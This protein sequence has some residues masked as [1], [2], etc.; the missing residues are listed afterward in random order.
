MGL[1]IV[2]GACWAL[3]FLPTLG[4]WEPLPEPAGA[5]QSQE[6]SEQQEDKE[7]GGAREGQETGDFPPTPPEPAPEEGALVV[8]PAGETPADDA[9]GV[10]HPRV[11]WPLGSEALASHLRGIAEAVPTIAELESLG[12]SAGGRE[13]FVLRLGLR[14]GRERDRPTLL[15][16]DHMGRASAGPEAM[17]T[18]GWRVASEYERDERL[19][20]L[21]AR[22]NLVLAP[23]LDPD[24]R[25]ESIPGFVL[26]ASTNDSATSPPLAATKRERFE[27]NFPS[28]W[29]PETLRPG[30]GRV[31]LS[32]PETLAAARYLTSLG[33]CA[34][35]LGFTALVPAGAPYRGAE[36]PDQDREVFRRL[37]AALERPGTRPLIPWF[38]LGSPGGGFFD[39]A[40][41]ARGI[42]PVLFGLPPEEEL[43]RTGA[44]P[45]VEDVCA[46]VLACLE[47]LPRVELAEE[48][49]ERLAVDTY[50]IDLRLRNAGVVPSTSALAR[51]REAPTDVV[52]ELAGAKLVATARRP[53]RGEDYTD[54]AFQVRSPLAAGTLA[55]GEERWL[56]LWVEAGSGAEVSVT[57]SSPWS[58][59]TD[60]HSTLP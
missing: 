17:V 5:P 55:G 46:R 27:H 34:V 1:D 14:D 52:L 50:Q 48:A 56:R 54:P 45:F 20:A 32:K 43:A 44:E 19:Q 23:A 39:F 60:L 10:V 33:G 49:V 13:I 37:V 36:L 24:L 8:A 15:L 47:I 38:E 18:L 21:L 26:D 2:L 53:S 41:Q 7:E 28:G 59:R 4:A 12:R 3:I 29:Q 30:S 42:Y 22:T 16:V 31:S 58:G 57:A 51:R 9:P 25:S 35:V 11:E 6:E 40:Y